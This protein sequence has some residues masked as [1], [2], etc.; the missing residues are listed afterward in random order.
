MNHFLLTT[1]AIPVGS[2]WATM[3]A[4]AGEYFL[5]EIVEQAMNGERSLRGYRFPIQRWA[6]HLFRWP[7]FSRGLPAPMG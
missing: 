1:G 2:V 3:G 4:I 7:H 6:W 5:E